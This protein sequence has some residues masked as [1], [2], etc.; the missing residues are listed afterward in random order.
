MVI[1]TTGM[2]DEQK[3]FLDET[4]DTDSSRLCC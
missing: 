4:A 3:A 1:G 2:S